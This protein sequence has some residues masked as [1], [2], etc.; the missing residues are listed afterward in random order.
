ME[1]AEEEEAEE[2]GEDGYCDMM[3]MMM[4]IFKMPVWLISE[5]RCRVNKKP[6]KFGMKYVEL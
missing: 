4:M 2:G 5:F 3:M 1:K 6:E